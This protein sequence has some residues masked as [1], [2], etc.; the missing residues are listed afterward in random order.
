[1]NAKKMPGFTAEASF[2]GN[3]A[4]YQVGAILNGRRPQ[5]GE[6]LVQPAVQGGPGPRIFYC[7]MR[8]CYFNFRAVG[9]DLVLECS[10][11]TGECEPV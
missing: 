1:M 10:K 4:R 2:Y 11:T 9:L 6:A 7:G 3:S 5:V 8:A